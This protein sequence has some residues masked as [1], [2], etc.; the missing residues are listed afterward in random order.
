MTALPQT[1]PL[2]AI[3]VPDKRLR[4]LR[5]EVVDKLAE[6]MATRG[7][8]QPVV[9]QPEGRGF[10]LLVG[11][12]RVIAARQLGWSSITAVV[13]DGLAADE[14]LL[15]ELDEN[16]IRAD[17]SPAE[18]ALHLAER[19][20]LYE[21]LHPETK[22]GATGRGRPKS[23]RGGETIRFTKIAVAAGQSERTIQREIARAEQIT[24][25]FD[26]PG[27]TL[28]T[29]DELDALAKLPEPEQ[30][31]LIKRAKTGEPVSAKH[32][33][34]KLQ[35]ETRERELAEATEAASQALGEKRYGCILADPP[36]RFQPRSRETGMDRAADNHY[37]TMALDD[38]KALRVPAA[39][40]C[41]L[42]LWATVPLLPEAVEV[43]RAWGFDY[44]S[45]VIW[46]KLRP[47]T[48]YWTQNRAEF[49]LIGTRGNI[50]AP[51]VG[52]QPPQ[53]IQASR[54]KHSEKPANFVELIEQL[55][56]TTPKLEMFA[57]S[58][59]PC[60]DAWGNEVSA[61]QE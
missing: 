43:M 17:L 3:T 39:D 45:A 2:D 57:R 29:P 12:H 54:G 38:I 41:V 27:T 34:K 50:P 53:I 55:Y 30:R 25:L 44:K 59:R 58:A 36:W 20:R 35:R 23:R 15:V 51:A 32:V 22:H 26:V 60:W 42:F 37:P 18:R 49:L 6:S 8:I 4:K 14:A 21:K 13:L 40:D 47:G 1:I 16:L 9:V 7:L 24:G 10:N 31:K 56:P 48:G 33:N 5:L 46:D 52:T 11:A 19:K 28:D 61:P